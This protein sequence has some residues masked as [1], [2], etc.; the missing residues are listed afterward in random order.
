MTPIYKLVWERYGDAPRFI[1]QLVGRMAEHKI[2][3]QALADRAGF[4]ASH[5]S[6][7]LGGK[8][9]PQLKTLLVLD[10]ALDQLINDKREEV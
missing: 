4:A 9:V 6:A 7:W 5:V 10:E 3:Q 8:V 2:I 1:K